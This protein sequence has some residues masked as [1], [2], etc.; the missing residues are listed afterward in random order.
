MIWSDAWYPE[1][2]WHKYYSVCNVYNDMYSVNYK[3]LTKIS[4]VWC[5]RTP[6]LLNCFAVLRNLKPYGFCCAQVKLDNIRHLIGYVTCFVLA[7]KV[8]F[9]GY[10]M[11]GTFSVDVTDFDGVCQQTRF[12]VPVE[13]AGADRVLIVPEDSGSHR[14]REIGYS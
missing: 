10:L 12:I 7:R 8:P 14:H 2:D 5:V 1:H 11:P 3:I 6:T 13:S 9:C 4:V